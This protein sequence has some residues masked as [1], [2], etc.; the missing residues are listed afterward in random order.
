MAYAQ[1][2]VSLLAAGSSAKDAHN[3]RGNARDIAKRNEL[4][5]GQKTETDPAE[6]LSLS[7]LRKKKRSFSEET[8]GATANTTLG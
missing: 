4:N 7:S 1:A 8:S 5:A 6:L 2:I 3:S